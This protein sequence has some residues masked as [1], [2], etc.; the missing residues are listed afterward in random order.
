MLKISLFFALIYFFIFCF[1]AYFLLLVKI[2]CV[3]QVSVKWKAEDKMRSNVK[4]IISR[5]KRI[6][7]PKL[8]ALAIRRTEKLET[9]TVIMTMQITTGKLMVW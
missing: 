1:V 7:S 6:G 5:N 9:M 8:T 2:W 4:V 3:I